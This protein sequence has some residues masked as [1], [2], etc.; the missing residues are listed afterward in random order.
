MSN[1][2]AGVVSEATAALTYLPTDI[3][4]QRLQVQSA[5][6]SHHSAINSSGSRICS[7][8]YQTEGVKGFYRGFGP[9]IL[10][11]GPGSAVWWASYEACK[12]VIFK[13]YRWAG[14]HVSDAGSYHQGGSLKI[15][16]HL[17][18]GGFAGAAGYVAVNPLEVAK[19]R[20]QLLEV[21][22]RT[23]KRAL[24]SGYW[25]L[26][27]EVFVKEGIAGLYKGLKPRLL[28]RVPV[29]SVAFIGYEY[30]KE[31]SMKKPG[32]GIE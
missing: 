8:I 14:F 5:M 19:T 12:S 28:I 27:R 23:D 13:A 18:S 7:H 17:V 3:V 25:K 32:S 26:L 1:A 22:E 2:T 16:A 31:S 24:S 21:N 29:S 4:T 10:V 11:Y 6:S 15:M 20:L 30:M 9:Y